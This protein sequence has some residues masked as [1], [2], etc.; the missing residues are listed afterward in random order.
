MNITAAIPVIIL[1]AGGHAKVIAESLKRSGHE[2][3]GLITPEIK[4]DS[5]VFGHRVLGDDRVITAYSPDEVVLANGIGAL[6]RHD[7]RWRLAATMRN[8]GYTFTTIIHPSAIIASDVELSEGVQVMAR[9][10]I[11]PGTRIGSDSIINTGALVD[12]DCRIGKNCHLAPGVVLS[13][14]VHADDGAHIGTGTSV[15]Q[16]ISIG[17]NSIVAAASALYE[18]IPDGVTFTQTRHPTIELIET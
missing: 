12:H 15:I 17:K 18:D 1:G 8:L 5:R 14:G 4:E 13:G 11:Q 7:L 3:L 6:P 9:S 10:V 2:V 16:N